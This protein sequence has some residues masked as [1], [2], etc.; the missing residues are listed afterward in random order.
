MTLSEYLSTNKITQ[1][2]FA[3]S[4]GATQ[5]AVGYWVGGERC[6]QLRLMQRITD[7]TNGAVTPN[8]FLP[9]APGDLRPP[10]PEPQ[11]AAE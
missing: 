10:V 7:A 5:Q 3:E 8:D 4:I 2:A 9:P 6:P 11:E 1:A